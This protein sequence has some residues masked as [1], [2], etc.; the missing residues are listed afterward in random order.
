MKTTADYLDELRARFKV[1]S[2]Y[3]LREHT[4][5]RLQ[6]ISRYRT[7]KSSFDDATA[8]KVSAWL[9]AKLEEVLIDMNAQRARD[10]EIR[11]AWQRIAAGTAAVV[12]VA[13]LPFGSDFISTANAADTVL[14]ILCQ[15]IAAALL[16][17]LVASCRRLAPVAALALLSACSSI[18]HQRG[19]PADW[20]QLH[21]VVHREG[22]MPCEPLL[23]GCAVADFCTRRCDVYLRVAVPGLEAH[24]RAHCAGLDH[25]GES[26]M[27][28]AW[29]AYKTHGGAALC[30]ARH[31]AQQLLSGY[32]RQ[33]DAPAVR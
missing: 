8:R 14:C 16:A 31:A 25:P 26:T 33:T 29:A 6:Q 32:P 3:A 28:A 15:V 27:A 7:K 17:A 10:K 18:D 21:V 30:D 2:D 20:P 19:A 11:N 12:I 4:G 5:W 24:E 22:F 23:S 9:D 1:E 13:A